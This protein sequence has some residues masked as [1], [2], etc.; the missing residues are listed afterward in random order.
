MPKLTIYL[1][2]PVQH[3]LDTYRSTGEGRDMAASALAAAAITEYLDR[4]GA[5]DPRAAWRE[6]A[7]RA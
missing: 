1:P 5:V 3:R 4:R 6:P 2:Y 7:A